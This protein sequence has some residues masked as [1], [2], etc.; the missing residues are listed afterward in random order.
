MLGEREEVYSVDTVPVAIL[1]LVGSNCLVGQR[2]SL[3]LLQTEKV[4]PASLKL[5]CAARLSR[6]FLVLEKY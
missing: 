1:I 4:A 5:M 6:I 3:M 2:T